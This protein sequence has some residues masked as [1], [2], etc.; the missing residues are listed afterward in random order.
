MKKLLGYLLAAAL[1]AVVLTGC[2]SSERNDE[3]TETSGLSET[4]TVIS[5]QPV[6]ESDVERE[7][8]EDGTEY[9]TS[10]IQTTYPD[11]T[12]TVES[13]SEIFH[14]DGSVYCESQLSMFH[15]DGRKTVEI[16][17]TRTDPEGNVTL[18]E[19]QTLEYDAGGRLIGEE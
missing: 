7:T 15:D 11:G 13:K 3:M 16:S 4:E 12:V 19:Q 14:T 8:A 1:L 2:G 18:L 6:V 9:V 5:E 17:T 10:L